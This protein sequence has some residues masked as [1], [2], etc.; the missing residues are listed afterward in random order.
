MNKE[1]EK[2]TKYDFVYCKTCI[3]AKDN[4]LYRPSL[5]CGKHRQL[6]NDNTITTA[7]NCCMGKDYKRK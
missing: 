4:Q 7:I 1:T 3:W 6:I 5:F 2:K